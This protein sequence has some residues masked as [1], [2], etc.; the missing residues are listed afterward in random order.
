MEVN[1]LI[2]TIRGKQV[3]IDSDL[4]KLYDVE[5]KRL[6]EQVRRNIERF[7]DDFMFQ[8]SQEEYI[9]LRSQ[10]ATSNKGR[11]GRR[12]EPYVFTEQGVSMLSSVL[13]SKKAIE[14]NVQIMRAFVAIRRFL[15]HNAQIFEKVSSIEKKLLVHDSK[16]DQIF[17]LIEERDLKPQKGIFFDGQIFDAYKFFADI[18]K[19]AVK[20]IVL[21]DN[22]VDESVLVLFSKRKKGVKVVIHTKPNKKLLLD[23]QKFNSQYDPV[24]IKEFTKSHDRFLIIDE[25]DM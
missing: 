8:L 7:P 3:I 21:V 20:S 2:H 22:Y 16:I 11:G 14:V 17:S 23:L 5:T 4:A 1:S 6:N 13:H 15:Q 10:F 25:T 24:E 18:I 9:S 19:G 12:F